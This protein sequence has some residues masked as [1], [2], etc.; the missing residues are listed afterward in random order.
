[1]NNNYKK[2]IKIYITVQNMTISQK[3]D[4]IKMRNKLIIAITGI[5]TGLGNGLFGSGGGTV[6]VPCMEKF[7]DVEE[8]KA[9]ATA[10]AIILPLSLISCLF[11][12]RGVDIQL[13][14]AVFVSIG[15]VIGGY[16]GAKVLGKISGKWLHLIFGIFMLLAAVRSVL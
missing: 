9:H 1:M 8:H 13:M 16:I 4:M 7:L 15:G 10:I 6:A 14:P 5:I 2:G 12:L 11:Y 3:K